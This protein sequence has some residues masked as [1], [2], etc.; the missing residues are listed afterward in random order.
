[1]TVFFPSKACVVVLNSAV[2]RQVRG[3]AGSCVVDVGLMM[4]DDMMLK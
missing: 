1:M 4:G 3:Y 2:E